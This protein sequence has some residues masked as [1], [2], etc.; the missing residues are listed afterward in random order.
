MLGASSLGQ[1]SFFEA[2]NVV[3]QK[4]LPVL[5]VIITPDLRESPLANQLSCSLLSL[6]QNFGL[7][8]ESL[9]ANPDEITNRISHYR[10]QNKPVCI[11]IQ[12]E[13]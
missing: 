11:E 5:F 13:K 12:L 3:A 2:L 10:N 4:N 8:T 1:G 6:A 9:A 7:Q